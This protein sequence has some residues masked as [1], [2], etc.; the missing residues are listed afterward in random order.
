MRVRYR[1]V[2]EQCGTGTIAR[3]TLQGRH[4]GLH[5]IWLEPDSTLRLKDGRTLA[6]SLT[7]LVGDQ[8]EFESTEAAVG[9]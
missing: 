5:P 1:V 7:D 6:I 3:G 9:L 8:A 4:A 2:V